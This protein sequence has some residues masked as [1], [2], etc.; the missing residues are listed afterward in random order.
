MNRNIRTTATKVQTIVRCKLQHFFFELWLL[1]FPPPELPISGSVPDVDADALGGRRKLPAPLLGVIPVD[2]LVFLRCAP[3]SSLGGRRACREL[4]FCDMTCL[5]YQQL[6]YL[7]RLLYLF[8]TTSRKMNIRSVCIIMLY[9][10]YGCS[11]SEIIYI[12]E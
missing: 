10:R 11:N 4:I 9:N 12:A 7:F 3:C 8:Q 2:R 1:L 5:F 6:L